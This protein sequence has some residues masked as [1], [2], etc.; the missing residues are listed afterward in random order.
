[1]KWKELKSIITVILNEDWTY[2]DN[3]WNEM[4]TFVFIGEGRIKSATPSIKP[5]FLFSLLFRM[6]ELKKVGWLRRM[7]HWWNSFGLP[8]FVCSA[9]RR[10]ARR[11][12]QMEGLKGEAHNKWMNK[13]KELLKWKKWMKAIVEFMN[14]WSC[15]LSSWAAEL[16]LGGLR[17][18]A[19]RRQPAQR[20]D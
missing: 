12:N 14:E 9:K 20:E 11:A 16:S 6:G 17:A 5:N 1:M 2:K 15:V 18:A 10:Q 19:S 7:A 13:W 3:C 4:R 8:S